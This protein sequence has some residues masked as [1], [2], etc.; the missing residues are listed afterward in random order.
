MYP[1]RSGM[2]NPA[3]P[4][5]AEPRSGFGEDPVLLSQMT[6]TDYFVPEMEKQNFI[7][8]FL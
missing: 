5:D 8:G 4:G 6:R 7:A 1:G 2:V 3:G